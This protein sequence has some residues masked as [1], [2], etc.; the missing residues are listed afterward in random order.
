VIVKGTTVIVFFFR[1]GPTWSGNSDSTAPPAYVANP[2]AFGFAVTD[3]ISTYSGQQRR[4][5][6]PTGGANVALDAVGAFD[7]RQVTISTTITAL[8]I[9]DGRGNSGGH[10]QALAIGLCAKGW[11][12]QAAATYNLNLLAS[13]PSPAKDGFAVQSQSR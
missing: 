1:N 9:S 8:T 5:T 3:S 12:D 2:S 10:T 7:G 6:D 4:N 13:Q 11:R